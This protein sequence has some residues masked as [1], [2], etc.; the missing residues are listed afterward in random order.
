MLSGNAASNL[1]TFRTLSQSHTPPVNDHPPC[2]MLA[3]PTACSTT[4]AACCATRNLPHPVSPTAH[5]G[6]RV[7]THLSR[8]YSMLAMPTACSPAFAACSAATL[9]RFARSAPLN[10][11]VPRAMVCRSTSGAKGMFCKQNMQQHE[12]CQTCVLVKLCWALALH[13]CWCHRRSTH[14]SVKHT[15]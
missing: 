14:V 8:A 11:G 12:D 13:D 7:T 10:P 6:S 3:M 15:P 1:P 2:P 5:P 4:F 9:T